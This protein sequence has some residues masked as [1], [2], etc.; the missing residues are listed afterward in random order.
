MNSFEQYARISLVMTEQEKPRSPEELQ[1]E[2]RLVFYSLP[3]YIP[4]GKNSPYNVVERMQVLTHREKSEMKPLLMEKF[5]GLL[6]KSP[7]TS[8]YKK[9]MNLLINKVFDRGRG[10][11]G[12]DTEAL[13]ASLQINRESGIFTLNGA[14]EGER[15]L[16]DWSIDELLMHVKI[17][18]QNGEEPMYPAADWE[19]LGFPEA[20]FKDFL[21]EWHKEFTEHYQLPMDRDIEELSG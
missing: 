5:D 15:E 13:F 2:T 9:L 19:I 17:S 1:A 6:S 11:L 14:C 12:L 18:L 20:K 21:L 16:Y 8:H 10:A 3:E 7:T 4:V